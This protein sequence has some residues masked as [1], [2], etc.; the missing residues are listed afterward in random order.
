MLSTVQELC[1][2]MRGLSLG[3][4]KV[5]PTP[6]RSASAASSIPSASARLGARYN[7][8][9]KL[10]FFNLFMFGCWES[11]GKGGWL[12]KGEMRMSPARC[13]FFYVSKHLENST[14]LNFMLALGGYSKLTFLILWGTNEK[15][16]VVSNIS[17]SPTTI[18]SSTSRP[19]NVTTKMN[20][21]YCSI[22]I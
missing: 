21:P 8:S 6:V 20:C 9:P 2:W 11:F 12:G 14:Q 7:Y 13:Y 15:A 17:I 19:R 22:Y 3:L 16:M 4:E 18:F 1:F 5:L 10:L